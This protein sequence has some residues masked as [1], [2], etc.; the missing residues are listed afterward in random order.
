MATLLQ[1]LPARKVLDWCIRGQNLTARQAYELGLVTHLTNQDKM[2]AVLETLLAEILVNSPTAIR[3]GL[4]AY[5]ELRSQQLHQA[6]AYLRGM[7][8][9][10]LQTEDATEGLAAFREKRKPKWT[11]R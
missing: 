4:Q 5:D 9:Q 7:L 8:D 2:E 11:G 3:M 10:V 6:H 1:T